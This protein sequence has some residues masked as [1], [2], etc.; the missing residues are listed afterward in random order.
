MIFF[1]VQ[2][3]DSGKTN[4]QNGHFRDKPIEWTISTFSVWENEN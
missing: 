3:K 1:E 2:N 4:N